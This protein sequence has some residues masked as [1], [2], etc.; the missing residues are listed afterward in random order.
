MSSRSLLAAV[1]RLTKSPP[2]T[3]MPALL[4]SLC[5]RMRCWWLILNKSRIS[6]LEN[7]CQNIGGSS[8]VASFFASQLATIQ[9]ISS[10]TSIK[11]LCDTCSQCNKLVRVETLYLVKTQKPELHIQA[12][13]YSWV[14]T[15]LSDTLSVCTAVISCICPNV[16]GPCILEMR[17]YISI[18]PFSR[19]CFFETSVDKP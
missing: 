15:K 5:F 1:L 8:V 3:L 18:T 7:L 11:K 12:T 2:M 13:A 10:G 4:N 19:N 9:E 14:R 6:I 16:K 17:Q